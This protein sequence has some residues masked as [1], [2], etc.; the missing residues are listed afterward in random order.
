M[1]RGPQGTLFGKNTTA[2]AI[3]VISRAP[4][5]EP[6]SNAEVSLG[7]DNFVQAKGSVSGP[8]GDKIAGRLSA[9]LT[10][11]DGLLH[12]VMTGEKLN[13][14]DNYAVRG[15]LLLEPNDRLNLRLI[16]D[17]SNLDSACCTTGLSARRPKPTQSRSPVSG[18]GGGA[19]LRAAE[20]QRLR[21][22]VRHRRGAASSTRK[23]AA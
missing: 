19:R 6:E 17:V 12:N 7:G 10:Q 11:R 22:L 13:E 5:F 18:A 15:Q 2:G 21:P 23:T 16:A 4:T 3:H 14:L 1:L 8:L 9:Q 20:P